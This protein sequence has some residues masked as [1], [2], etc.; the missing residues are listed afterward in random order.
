MM[1]VNVEVLKKVCEICRNCRMREKCVILYGGV[2][3][4]GWM[5]YC[6]RYGWSVDGL[7][8]SVFWYGKLRSLEEV[9]ELVRRDVR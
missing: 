9:C 2:R 5:V 7:R 8:G 6:V 3:F 4:K 1:K